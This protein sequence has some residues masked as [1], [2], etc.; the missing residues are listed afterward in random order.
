MILNGPALYFV[1]KNG[2]Y[3]DVFG[4][5]LRHD[6]GTLFDYQG[7]DFMYKNIQ[8]VKDDDWNRLQSDSGRLD[9]QAY[10]NRW[11]SRST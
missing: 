4:K 8:L 10:N 1:D 5:Y 7:I 9:W 2:N 11:D 6:N 3:H